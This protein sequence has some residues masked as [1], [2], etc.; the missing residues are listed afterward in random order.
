MAVV[1]HSYISRRDRQSRGQAKAPKVVAVERAIAH[2]K[3]IQNRPGR[4]KADGKA[5]EFFNQFEGGLDGNDLRKMIKQMEDSKVVVHK[6]TLAPEIDPLSKEAYTREVMDKIAREKG[7]DLNW[8]AVCHGNTEHPHIHVVVL[9]KDKNGKSV[10]IGKENYPKLRE[11]GDRYLERWQPLELERSRQERERRDKEKLAERQK[12]RELQRQERILE[13]LELPWLH[14]KIVREMYEPYRDWKEKEVESK[15]SPDRDD[16]SKSAEKP[17]RLE[18]V[19]AAG[20]NWTKQNSLSELQDL[21]RYLWD[22]YDERIPLPQYKNLV[23]WIA[24]KEQVEAKGKREREQK[25]GVPKEKDAIHYLKQEY[26]KDSSYDLLRELANKVHSGKAP[27]L[28]VDDYQKLRKWMEAAD[29]Q[30]WSGVVEKQ[31]ELSKAQFAKEGAQKNMPHMQRAQNP[32]QEQALRNPVIG[33]FMTG[34]SVANEL[35]RW[36]PVTDQ[37]DR[38]KEAGDALQAEKQGKHKQYVEPGREQESKDRDKER[39]ERLDESIDE[40]KKQ[41]EEREKKRK[42]K[43]RDDDSPFKRDPW[44]R[45]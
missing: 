30:R 24:D 13:G 43:E 45:W 3:Y 1:V 11:Y 19:R 12:Q 7:L 34:A 44:G 15:G 22:N 38:L 18:T 37:R 41:R 29:R 32:I 27:R 26:T 14:K 25:P 8:M 6:L 17:E 10:W 35:V 2:V 36:I 39:I 31:L 28:P 21:N 9:G 42:E 40:N 5:R 16:A 33:L 4:D 20:K 23:S